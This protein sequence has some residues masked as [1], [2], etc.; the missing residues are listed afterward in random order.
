ML[1]ALDLGNT[2]LSGGV[3]DGANLVGRLR[4]LVKD[5]D[6]LASGL[7]ES[8]KGFDIDRVALASVNPPWVYA[9]LDA[10]REA[11][12]CDTVR[13]GVDISIPVEAK[14]DHPGQVGA[15]RLLDALAAF[16]RVGKACMVVDFGSALTVDVVSE[17]GAYLGGAIAPGLGMSAAALHSGTALLP[18]VTLEVPQTATG[19]NSISCIQ[20]GL[21]WGT[22]G[23]VESLVARLKTEHPEVT[24]VLATGTDAELFVPH[25]DAIDEMIPEL[26]LVGIRL[27]IDRENPK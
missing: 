24:R 8:L 1:L 21:F 22:I 11:V 14:V 13:I 15:D 17:D 18:E 16:D 12:S 26:T 27:T 5:F 23:M 10:I 6:H 7:T 20:S 2:S 25:T 4:V 3:F 9:V 19:T